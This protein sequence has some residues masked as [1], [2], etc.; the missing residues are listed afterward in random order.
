M[1][2]TMLFTFQVAAEHNSAEVAAVLVE[3]GA[4]AGVKDDS[5]LSSLVLLILK[6]PSVVR[7]CSLTS[8][9]FGNILNE[10]RVF[11]LTKG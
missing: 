2:F 5:G 10:H 6:M 7:F 4:F 1:L 11:A 8:E 3:G 9:K